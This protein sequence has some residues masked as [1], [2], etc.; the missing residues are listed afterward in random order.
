M[1]WQPT[2]SN[3]GYSEIFGAG[4]KPGQI[5]LS[6]KLYLSYILGLTISLTACS[7]GQISRLPTPTLAQPQTQLVA[8]GL[9]GPIGLAILPDGTLLVAE[10]GTGERDESAGVSLITP[11]GQ[12]GRLISGLASSRDAGDLAGVNTVALSPDADKIYLGNFGQGHLWTLLL[13]PEQRRQGLALPD[14]PLTP[15]QLTP[16][17]LR[18]NNVFLTNPFDITFDPE[19]IPVVSDASGNGVAKENPNG[20]TRF[21]HRFDR[22]PDPS[23][24]SERVTIDPVPTGITRIGQEYYVTLTGGCPFPKG[25]GRLV[26]IDEQRRER[27][28]VDNLNMPIDVALGPDGTIWVLE[29]AQFTPS[30]SCFTGEGYQANTG[31]LSRLQPDGSLQTMLADLN[32]PGAVLPLD[33]GSI[34]ISEVFTG[35]VIR[36][37]FP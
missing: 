15:E 11:D 32:F 1:T 12:V 36:I 31:R 22:L 20:T 34:Y 16:A 14:M 17:M 18:L 28:V 9:I 29:F 19:G 7:G 10:A 30:A 4:I 35:R 2:G 23:A 27:T 8:E 25:G 37:I 13:T 21:L 24:D 26:A 6:V 5:I 3:L 33:D